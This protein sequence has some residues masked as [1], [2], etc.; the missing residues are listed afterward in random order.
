MKKIDRTGER[1]LNI[2]GLEMEILEYKNNKDIKVLFTESGIVRHTDYR[3]FISGKVYPTWRNKNSEGYKSCDECD[4]TQVEEIPDGNNMATAITMGVGLF[5]L[6][7]VGI[8][9]LVFGLS[10]VF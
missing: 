4:L 6:L 3:K 10:A 5:I 2:H 7:S 1:N 9:G 8:A